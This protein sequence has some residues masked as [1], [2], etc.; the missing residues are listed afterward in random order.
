MCILQTVTYYRVSRIVFG[1]GI[2]HRA[3]GIYALC[4]CEC[5]CVCERERER[6]RESVCETE[7]YSDGIARSCANPASNI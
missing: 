6:E 3:V 4:V 7:T 5:V 2:M 1:L